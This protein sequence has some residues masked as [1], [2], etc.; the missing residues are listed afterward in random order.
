MAANRNFS[1]SSLINGNPAKNEEVRA[2]A[3]T[4]SVPNFRITVQVLVRYL[5]CTVLYRY[6]RVYCTRA[7]SNPISNTS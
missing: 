2:R 3:T 1:G 4:V 7:V 5:Y 6:S